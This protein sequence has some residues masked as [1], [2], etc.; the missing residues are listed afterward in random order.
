MDRAIGLIQELLVSRSNFFRRQYGY[1][2]R[3]EAIAEQFLVNEN[4]YIDLIG[5]I[6]GLT[7]VPITLTFPINMLPADF[8]DAV[9]IRPSAEQ[10]T[11]ELQEFMSSSQ[12]NCAICQDQIT[13]DGCRLRTCGH[14]YHSSCIRAWFNA[15]ARCPICRRD[16]REDRPDQTSSASH[17]IPSQQPSPLEEE[18]I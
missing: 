15:S 6:V 16:I 8:S 11:A 14:P 7:A 5:R 13:E 17:E 18:D 9:S 12:Q 3:R 4:A 2:A 1:N 10:I